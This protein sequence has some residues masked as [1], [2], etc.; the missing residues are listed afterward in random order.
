MLRGFWNKSDTSS[1]VTSPTTPVELNSLA[2]GRLEGPNGRSAQCA[3]VGLGERS[4]PL[5]GQDELY[6][7]V[8][9]HNAMSSPGDCDALKLILGTKERPVKY[10]LSSQRSVLSF[11]SC[12]GERGIW[13]GRTHPNEPCPYKWNWT[14]VVLKPAFVVEICA[15]QKLTFL[16]VSLAPPEA[17][18]SRLCH[19]FA[20]R[21]DGDVFSHPA[22]LQNP[23]AQASGLNGL[24]DEINLYTQSYPLR[25][26]LSAF[27]AV[28][29]GS[30]IV[31]CANPNV[32][33]TWRILGI[34]N[35]CPAE[36]QHGISLVHILDSATKE[37]GSCGLI[38]C[39]SFLQQTLQ[40]RS[41]QMTSLQKLSGCLET[42][43]VCENEDALKE[44]KLL[45][46][47]QMLGFVLSLTADH[48][49]LSLKPQAKSSTGMKFLCHLFSCLEGLNPD[50]VEQAMSRS[51]AVVKD[52]CSKQTAIIRKELFT[53][54]DEMTEESADDKLIEVVFELWLKIMKFNFHESPDEFNNTDSFAA[55]NRV[56]SWERM[57]ANTMIQLIFSDIS[58]MHHQHIRRTST[59]GLEHQRMQFDREKKDM[60]TN[61]QEERR[62]IESR[63]LQEIEAG[64][65]REEELTAQL[66]KLTE[67]NNMLVKQ[68]QTWQEENKAMKEAL[69]SMGEREKNLERE[70]EEAKYRINKLEQLQVES[71]VRPSHMTLQEE[72]ANVKAVSAPTTPSS[73][74]ASS[75]ELQ[76]SS[77]C[78]YPARSH[79]PSLCPEEV[80]DFWSRDICKLLTDDLKLRDTIAHPFSK[81]AGATDGSWENLISYLQLKM[82]PEHLETAPP[83]DI[84]MAILK[85]WSRKEVVTVRRFCEV[86]NHLEIFVVEQQLKAVEQLL[87]EPSLSKIVEG[88]NGHLCSPAFA[89]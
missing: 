17:F 80:A 61:S 57:R 2:C 84:L 71:K 29:G 26:T 48:V 1:L 78:Y 86:S 67:G 76:T 16:T 15:K 9:T 42:L 39:L 27:Q 11:V 33:E 7:I 53:L 47:I 28:D 13:K 12:C 41:A 89:V 6:A 49:E 36:E 37:G 24:E 22:D 62:S 82:Y 43:R 73:T 35:S 30:A 34:H 83:G 66:Q 74:L 59:L 20:R 46:V 4:R 88:S 8:T 32:P 58:V 3:L 51:P 31:Y 55:M 75:L 10:P 18:K 85:V 70:L 50:A 81:I 45:R 56:R 79:R 69:Q 72:A 63:H 40:Y 5:G 38:P 52:P 60:E 44:Q 77:D 23:I 14:L 21:P 54:L 87:K 68:S 25:Y 65:R 64:R 19:M